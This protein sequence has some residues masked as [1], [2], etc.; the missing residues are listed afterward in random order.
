MT[1]FDS[2][3]PVPN[4]QETPVSVKAPEFSEITINEYGERCY[5]YNGKPH[6]AKTGYICLR[7]I[8]PECGCGSP[9]WGKLSPMLAEE[10][11]R[12]KKQFTKKHAYEMLEFDRWFYLQDVKNGDNKYTN[13]HAVRARALMELLGYGLTRIDQIIEGW[14]ADYKAQLE[15]ARP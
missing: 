6:K 10:K 1:F 11:P 3:T 14:E 12:H 9:V 2:S 13:R 7:C 4:G 5:T 15:A 8:Y